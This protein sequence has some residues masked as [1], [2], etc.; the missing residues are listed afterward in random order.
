MDAILPLDSLVSALPVEPVALRLQASLLVGRAA[1]N[2][3]QFSLCSPRATQTEA[4]GI[5]E[6]KE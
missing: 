5:N 3:H 1:F 2:G 4:K 6:N